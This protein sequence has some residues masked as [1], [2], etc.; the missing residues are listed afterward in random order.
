[1][2]IAM[3]SIPQETNPGA[4]PEPVPE[5]S[6]E[7]TPLGDPGVK[8]VK[9]RAIGL[10][11][12]PKPRSNK[13]H[14]NRPRLGK[15]KLPKDQR[16]VGLPCRVTTHSRDMLLKLREKNFGWAI[17]KLVQMAEDRGLFKIPVEMI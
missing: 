6:S 7:P 3:E 14:S 4:V 17:D 12:L 1:M 8:Y 9:K 15:P 11:R 16:R 13:A 2:D 10:P 5:L